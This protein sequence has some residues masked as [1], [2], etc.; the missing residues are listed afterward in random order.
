MIEGSVY[1][2]NFR[3]SPE[4]KILIIKCRKGERKAQEELFQLTFPYALNKSLRF[5]SKSAEAKE[6]VF[7]G[8]LKVFTQLD[9]Y[10]AEPQ[11][12]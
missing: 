7:D 12:E 3:V 6:V 5:R 10:N 2:M 11:Y 8:F 9:K 4:L 1:I